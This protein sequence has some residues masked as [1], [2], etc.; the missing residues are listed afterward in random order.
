MSVSLKIFQKAYVRKDGRAAIYLQLILDREI[1]QIPLD[2]HWFNKLFSEGKCLERFKGDPEAR[3]MNLIIGDTLARANEILIQFRL[4]RRVLSADLFL[5]EYEAGSPSSDF[6][7]YMEAKMLQRLREREIKMGTYKTQLVALNHLKKWK[8]RLP[9]ELLNERTAFL[10]DAYLDRIPEIK[11]INGKFGR[12]R[13]FKT[14]LNQAKSDRIE[15]QNPYDYFKIKYT[16]GRFQPLHKA[17]LIQL[18]E[19]YLA[20]SLEPSRQ[21]SLRGFLFVCL[22][23]M[24]HGDLRRFSMDWLD[25]DFF[26]FVPE[27]TS[28]H[29]TSVRVPASPYAMRLLADEVAEK[30]KKGFFKSVAEQTQNELVRGIGED[31]ELST[32]LCYQV[33]RETFATL[34]MEQ[35]GKLEVLASF[36]G[37][38]T[39]K[40]SEK[41]VK[42]RDQR[43][44]EESARISS[45]LEKVKAPNVGL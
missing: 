3:D 10:F 22:T 7:K 35:D 34:Y 29:G 41:Y 1:R 5:Q 36:M 8:K 14:Y 2:I 43:K 13:D 37:H 33:G 16:M 27:K 20:N 40:M 38:T 39:T 19:L 31:L 26:D 11:T 42:I 4:R 44:R 28:R 6:I 18:W 17:E 9:F 15:F 25:G 23:G 45:F 12:H 32:S 24:R 30:G 21:D